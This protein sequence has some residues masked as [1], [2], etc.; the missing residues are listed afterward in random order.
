MTYVLIF[1]CEHAD[2]NRLIN[3]K[4]IITNFGNTLGTKFLET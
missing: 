2:K 1:I 4:Y 3:T